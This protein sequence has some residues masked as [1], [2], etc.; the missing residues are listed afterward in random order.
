MCC[1]VLIEC[2]RSKNRFNPNAASPLITYAQISARGDFPWMAAL[3][4][5]LKGEPFKQ[6]CGGTL[7]SPNLV[8]TGKFSYYFY[9]TK[10]FRRQIFKYIHILY[11]LF[12]INFICIKSLFIRYFFHCNV[13]NDHA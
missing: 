8:L 10:L 7:V 13:L 3:Y 2:G 1:L 9:K 4:Y 6:I 12:S 5:R 11:Y